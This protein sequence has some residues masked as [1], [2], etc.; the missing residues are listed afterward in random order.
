M[1][2]ILYTTKGILSLTEKLDCV[3][4]TDSV[5]VGRFRVEYII[6]DEVIQDQE[7]V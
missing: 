3:T 7:N 4:C 1:T 5:G 6:L 2:K